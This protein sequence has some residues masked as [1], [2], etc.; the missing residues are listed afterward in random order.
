MQNNQSKYSRKIIVFVDGAVYF[1][2]VPTI[3]WHQGESDKKYTN[4]RNGTY[5]LNPP[6]LR[7]LEANFEIQF[8]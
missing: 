3:R 6:P 8:F 5:F 1:G 2:Y 7:I 4:V